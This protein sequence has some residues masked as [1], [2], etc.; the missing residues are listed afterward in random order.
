MLHLWKKNSQERT[1]KI[2]R[3]VRDQCH[4]TGK[5]RS[6]AHSIS[7]LR[8]NVPNK[9]PVVFTASQITKTFSVLI[10]KEVTKID[11]VL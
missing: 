8:F 6:A 3:Q 2:K 7:N 4:F 11:K 10:E 5:Y 1:V 9:I